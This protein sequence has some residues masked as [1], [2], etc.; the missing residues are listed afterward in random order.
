LNF[1]LDEPLALVKM[2]PCFDD[3]VDL[4]ILLMCSFHLFI[5]D[6]INCCMLQEIMIEFCR[7][8]IEVENMVKG[9]PY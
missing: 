3:L 7:C 1:T 2:F 5:H 4:Y 8:P 6:S 9:T